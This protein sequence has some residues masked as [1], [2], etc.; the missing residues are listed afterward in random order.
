MSPHD[1]STLYLGAQML[2]KTDDRG[3][4]WTAVSPDLSK[5]RPSRD[6]GEGATI[7][8][9]VASPLGSAVLWAGTDDGNL[10]ISRDGGSS[11]TNVA[12]RIAGLPADTGGSP[13]AWA[14][15]LEASH[16]DVATAYAAFDDHRNDDFGVYLFRTRDS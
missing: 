14:S 15:S 1:S 13:R 7:T 16:F 2:L 8:A 3:E 6:T 4:S 9:I 5:G 11:W 12:A 10:H